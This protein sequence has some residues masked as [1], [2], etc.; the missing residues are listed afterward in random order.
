MVGKKTIAKR[1]SE[2]TTAEM[3]NGIEKLQVD[4]AKWG[5]DIPSPNEED[6]RLGGEYVP[7][8]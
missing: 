6:Y 5:L 1:S 8:I 4:F 2:A 7:T 3:V